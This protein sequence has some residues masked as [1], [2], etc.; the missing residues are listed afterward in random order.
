MSSAHKIILML[1]LLLSAGS[2]AAGT[3]PRKTLAP[4]ASE[5]ALSS[6]L[7]Q[8]QARQAALLREQQKLQRATAQSMSAPPAPPPAPA[9]M[10]AKTAPAAS[11]EAAESVTNVQT[12]GVDEGGI[13]KLHGKHLVMLRRGKLF[14]VQ[15]GGNAL[16]PVASL[17]AFAPGSDPSGSWYDEMLIDGDTVVVIGYSYSRGGTEI[18]LFDIAADGKLA[19]RATYHLRSNDYYSS[20]NYASR[21]IGSKLVFY[22]PLSLNLRRGD[23]FGGFPA[24]R[25]WRPDAV[26]SDFKR[27]APATRI[28]RTDEEPEPG[29]GLTLHTVTVCDLAQRD[30]RCEATAVMGP[31]GRVFYVSGES[32]F[33]WTTR[34]GSDSGVFRIPLDGSAPS[35]LKVAGAPVDQFSFLESM[36]GHLNVLLRAEG[37]GDAMW[38]GAR[39]RGD[40]ALLRVPLA[41]FSD[42]RDSA[43]AGSY[44]PLPGGGGYGLQNRY[45]GPYLLYGNPG[46]PGRRKADQA[47]P[48]QPLYAV[49]W[50]DAGSVQAL[51]LPHGVERIEAL[52]NDA[53][54]IGA[55]GRDLHFSTIGLAG[56][57]AV[58][59]RY[60]RADAA[61][62]ESRSHGFFYK[63][64]TAGEGLIGLP[65]LGADERPGLNKPAASVLY[66]RNSS[67]Q[68]TELGALAARPGP[69]PDDGCRASCV[70]WY[71][72]ARPLFLQ[73][74]VFALLGYE[75]VEGALKEGQIREV[76]RVSYAPNASSLR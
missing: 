75:L 35:A 43:P 16:Q 76:R 20:R 25:R 15:V 69:A 65:I 67:L 33:V 37:Q 23:P 29:F 54:V 5:Q 27:I 21:L 61:Q 17:D 9:P 13:V 47:W 70:D 24:L 19:Y 74:R 40:M 22:S 44:H 58:A 68:L 6:Y 12:A 31:Q 63:P 50:A 2:H 34:R 46:N 11:A 14:T 71:G 18:G 55:Q 10:V 38:D 1:S 32:V 42:G 49:R 53:L 30:M 7:Q 51:S 39:G 3:A 64:Q 56:Q 41:T 8:L 48:R 28:Y 4:F 73:G 26:P 72:N 36:D 60:I 45:V 62:G 59:T 57:A 66:L 52:G